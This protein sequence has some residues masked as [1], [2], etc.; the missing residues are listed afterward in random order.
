[1]NH[2]P[3]ALNSPLLVTPSLVGFMYLPNAP[4]KSHR[5]QHSWWLAGGCPF[6]ALVLLVVVLRPIIIISLSF[7][8][9]MVMN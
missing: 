7:K 6:Q 3:N 4:S 9:C 2:T 1:M 8:L 5:P